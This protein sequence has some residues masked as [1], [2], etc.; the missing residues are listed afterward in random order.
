M[1]KAYGK[2]NLSAPSRN[3]SPQALRNYLVRIEQTACASALDC[4][5]SYIEKEFKKKVLPS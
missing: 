4:L 2:F 3:Q 1:W 5:V